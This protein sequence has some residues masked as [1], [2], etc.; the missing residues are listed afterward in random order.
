M[1]VGFVGLSVGGDPRHWQW[2]TPLWGT[3]GPPGG[4]RYL[5]AISTAILYLRGYRYGYETDV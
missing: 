2:G 1:R 5:Y 4:Y 3:Q